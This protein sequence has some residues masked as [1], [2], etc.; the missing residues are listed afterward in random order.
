MFSEDFP[1]G[2]QRT[3]PSLEKLHV[4][5]GLPERA[6]KNQTFYHHRRLVVF[7][8]Y[9]AKNPSF[10]GKNPKV[11]SV[12]IDILGPSTPGVP[13]PRQGREDRLILNGP[14]ASELPQGQRETK[15]GVEHSIEILAGID[16]RRVTETSYPRFRI[17][18]KP[19][20]IA[21][22]FSDN[23]ASVVYSLY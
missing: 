3:K 8:D 18:P 13:S 12:C 16:Q 15:A 10:S 20:L 17:R 14:S 9:I 11:V 2:Q 22:D 4:L 1:K 21:E 5:R 23:E 7:A 6:T 19:R